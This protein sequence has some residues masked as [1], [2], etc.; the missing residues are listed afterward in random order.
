MRLAERATE[1]TRNSGA[2]DYLFRLCGMTDQADELRRQVEETSALYYQYGKYVLDVELSPF[3]QAMDSFAA[4]QRAARAE[5]VKDGA[6]QRSA[7]SEDVLRALR[8]RY[9]VERNGGS[10]RAELYIVMAAAVAEAKRNKD[11]GHD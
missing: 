10:Y 5:L 8:A 9:E 2:Q 7:C 11:R 4:G 6:T 1:L 3:E